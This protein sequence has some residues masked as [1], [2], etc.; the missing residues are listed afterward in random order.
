MKTTPRG[1]KRSSRSPPARGRFLVGT[2][3]GQLRGEAEKSLVRYVLSVF[4]FTAAFLNTVV[5]SM[6]VPFLLGAAL[7]YV[8][9]GLWYLDDLMVETLAAAQWMGAVSLSLPFSWMI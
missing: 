1:M 9:D 2:V 7:S 6:I 3:A 8:P 4:E 5:Q